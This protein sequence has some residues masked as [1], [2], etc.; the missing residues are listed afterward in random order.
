MKNPLRWGIF[1]F[2]F[3]FATSNLV[4]QKVVVSQKELKVQEHTI[5]QLFEPN[6]VMSSKNR[7]AI[8]KKR[9]EETQRKLAMIDTMDISERKRRK[10][11]KDLVRTPYSTR[12]SKATAIVDTKFEDDEA[13]ENK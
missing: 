6:L 5:M 1:M 10:L 9:R 7:L 13:N 12:L 8:K 3:V 2:L 4:A 11:L